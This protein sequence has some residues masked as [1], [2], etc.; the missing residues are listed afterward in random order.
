MHYGYSCAVYNS[1]TSYTCA[2]SLVNKYLQL[3]QFI[4]LTFE[5]FTRF[6]KVILCMQKLDFVSERIISLAFDVISH[7]LQT[8]PVSSL[9]SNS[10]N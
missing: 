3:F 2:I 1:L 5:S 10:Y 7:I 8:G 4:I 9:I 6:N